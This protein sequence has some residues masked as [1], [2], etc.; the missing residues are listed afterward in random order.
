MAETD[1]IGA[2]TST[3]EPGVPPSPFT[4][5]EW[6]PELPGENLDRADLVRLCNRTRSVTTGIETIVGLIEAQSLHDD[7]GEDRYLGILHVSS[8]E[9]LAKVSLEFLHEYTE[10]VSNRVMARREAEALYGRN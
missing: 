6:T 3:N 8:L 5:F 7:C 10:D 9:S 1:S 4:R 2:H